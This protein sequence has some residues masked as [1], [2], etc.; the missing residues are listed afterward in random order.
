MRNLVANIQI[1]SEL[2]EEK[3]PRM[4]FS[5]QMLHRREVAATIP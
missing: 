4:I 2:L 1:I 3:N 5:G